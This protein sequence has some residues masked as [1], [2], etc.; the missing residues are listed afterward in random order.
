MPPISQLHSSKDAMSLGGAVNDYINSEPQDS[1]CEIQP[2]SIFQQWNFVWQ[3]P[4]EFQ[5]W[6]MS[7]M[8]CFLKALSIYYGP[9]VKAFKF[10]VEPY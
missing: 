3:R 5:S 6:V 8:S 1:Y 10:T 7:S 9:K 4:I 2:L